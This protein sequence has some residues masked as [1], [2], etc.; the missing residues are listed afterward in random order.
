[1]NNFQ[2]ESQAWNEETDV[3]AARLVREGTPP[4]QAM[5]QAV[6]IV[7]LRR[8]AKAL[9]SPPAADAVDPHVGNTGK[10]STRG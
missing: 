5:Q 4:W 7:S 1:M 8:R 10:P 2:W 6:E 9:K 3:E